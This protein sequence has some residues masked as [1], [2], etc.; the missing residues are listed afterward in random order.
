MRVRAV[1]KDANGVLEEVFSEPTAPVANVNDAPIAAPTINDTTP[2]EGRALTVDPTTIELLDMFWA[3]NGA[4]FTP[5]RWNARHS[6]AVTRLLPASDVVPATSNAPIGGGYPQ[7]AS[8]RC[9][10]APSPSEQ[11]LSGE[12]ANIEV[13]TPAET[14]ARVG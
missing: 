13:K 14:R 2:T 5:R 6:A 3:L 12:A 8:G 10:G 7:R 11:G 1:Y 4:T 9:A